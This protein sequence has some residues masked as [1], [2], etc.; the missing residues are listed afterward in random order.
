MPLFSRLS[1]VVRHS[2]LTCDAVVAEDARDLLADDGVMLCCT[3]GSP[4]N[5]W[6]AK[7]YRRLENWKV[8]RYA[9]TLLEWR[10]PRRC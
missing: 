6:M 7:P 9:Q 3:I 5:A 1:P 2:A 8:L 10:K 4:P